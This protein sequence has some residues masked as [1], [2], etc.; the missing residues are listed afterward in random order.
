MEPAFHSTIRKSAYSWT[1]SF[2]LRASWSSSHSALLQNGA[3]MVLWG[4]PWES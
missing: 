3:P 2:T 4:S 1:S